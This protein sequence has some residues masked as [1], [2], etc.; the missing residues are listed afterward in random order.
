METI[1]EILRGTKAEVNDEKINM[2]I[3]VP[4]GAVLSPTLFALYINDLLTELNIDNTCY[5]FADDLV[6]SCKGKENLYRALDIVETW[7]ENNGIE[8]NRAKSGIMC[9]RKD[10]RTPNP[11]ETTL[12]EY[13]IVNQYKYLGVMID[14]CLNLK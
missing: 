7:S 13:P 9:I 8:I 6:I 12:R 2:D 5:A 11:I 1:Q 3:G 4:Q 14:N 10:A